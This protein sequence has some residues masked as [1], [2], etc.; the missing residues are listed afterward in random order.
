V[1]P[2]CRTIEG[3]GGGKILGV[4]TRE[5]TGADPCPPPPKCSPPRWRAGPPGGEIAGIGVRWP[6]YAA[7]PL[8]ACSESAT[9]SPWPGAIFLLCYTGGGVD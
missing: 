7:R 1:P 8:R 6:G 4:P 5:R 2:P 9:L 3:E